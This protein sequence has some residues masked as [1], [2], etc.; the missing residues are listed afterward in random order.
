[1]LTEEKR[2]RIGH[3]VIVI[4]SATEKR[5]KTIHHLLAYYDSTMS[6]C[7]SPKLWHYNSLVPVP[8]CSE[9]GQPPHRDGHAHTLYVYAS[10]EKGME[11]CTAQCKMLLSCAKTAVRVLQF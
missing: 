3:R 6:C 9:M 2:D 5:D 7:I 4:S 11:P 10:C 8:T 1:M